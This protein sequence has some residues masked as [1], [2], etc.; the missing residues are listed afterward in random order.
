MKNLKPKFPCSLCKGD[1]LLRNFPGLPKVL[2]MWSSTSLVPTRHDG[3]A[4]S[5]SDV[6]FGKKKTIAKFPYMLCKGDHYSHLCLRMD[7]DSSLL[8]NLQLPIGYRKIPPNPSLVDGM[9]NMVPSSIS[10]IDQVVNLVSSSVE[11][12]TK[13]VDPVPSSVIPTLHMN[14]DPE[15]VDPFSPLVIPT[16]HLKSEPKVVDLVPPSIDPTSP[17]KSVT[18]VVDSV[19]PPV[20]PT[21]HLESEDVT[22][23]YLINIDSP[24]QG[25]TPPILMA[26][27][28]RNLMISIDWNHLIEPRLPSYMP[29]QITVLVCPWV[30]L[31]AKKWFCCR[32]RNLLEG[33]SRWFPSK[34]EIHKWIEDQQK[35][36]AE[37]QNK[38]PNLSTEDWLGRYIFTN[39]HEIFFGGTHR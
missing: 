16:L 19:P 36:F 29:F 13:V 8:E 31:C 20:D 11:P 10:Q 28:S 15:V 6:K 2:E 18:K 4:P 3:D 7:D 12:L 23:V 27:P 34:I 9:V 5:T 14:S 1:H 35:D 24:R 25:S 21:T 17:L 32:E 37:A 26:H 39:I 38:N 30:F 33:M 22:Q